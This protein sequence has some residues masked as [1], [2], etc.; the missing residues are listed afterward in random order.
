[1]PR[2]ARAALS[3]DAFLYSK[4]AWDTIT[5][6]YRQYCTD[7]SFTDYFWTVRIMHKP[8]WQVRIA[9]G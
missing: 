9:D 5:D 4:R 2:C 1:M 7:P 3:E 6:Q 8:L